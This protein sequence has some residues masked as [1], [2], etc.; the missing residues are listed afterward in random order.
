MLIVTG[1][2]YNTECAREN[3]MTFFIWRHSALPWER[4]SNTTD[5]QFEGNYAADNQR[6]VASCRGIRQVLRTLNIT[7]DAYNTVCAWSNILTFFHLETL[8]VTV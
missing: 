2:A 7:G 1:N 8:C 4:T 5:R 3:T 6:H